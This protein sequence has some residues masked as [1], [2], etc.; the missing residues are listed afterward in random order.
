MKNKTVKL[1]AVVMAAAS[2]TSAPVLAADSN[3]YILLLPK[4]EG[5]TYEMDQ[6][7]VADQ[8]SNDQYTVLLYKEGES[9]DV[10]VFGANEFVIK[11]AM[12]V[13]DTDF[14]AAETDGKVSFT[15]PAEDLSL[16]VTD[17]DEAAV[18]AAQTETEAETEI[19]TEQATETEADAEQTAADDIMVVAAKASVKEISEEK[20]EEI[21][22]LEQCQR[23]RVLDEKNGWSRIQFINK[24]GTLEE[25]S[26]KTSDLT[27]LSSLYV[28]TSNVNVR[29]EAS[30][31]A[32]K[33]G[34]IEKGKE[35]IVSDSSQEK[36]DKVMFVSDNTIREAYMFSQYLQPETAPTVDDLLT[37]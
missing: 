27:G 24:E 4:T 7:H 19:Q 31:T 28:T 12:G 25:G 22:V 10:T 29:A 17:V 20:A 1:L 23:V 33:L 32:E 6:E 8:Y 18:E 26:V 30:D 36:W 35:V 21:Y 14:A 34:K 5:V 9:V 3:D 37:K 11:D 13:D 16:N 15:M 2:L